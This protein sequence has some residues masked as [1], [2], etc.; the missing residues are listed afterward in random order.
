MK[1]WLPVSADYKE[2]NVAA[3]EKEP[4]SMLSLYRRLLAL[5]QSNPALAVGSYQAV[6]TGAADVFAFER[7]YAGQRLLV[8]L[9]FSGEERRIQM[10]GNGTAKVLL[11]TSLD[12]EGIVDLGDWVLP[13]NTGI[14]LEE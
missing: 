8:A 11:S 3:E 9:N 4:G 2:R 7:E 10:V 14:V 1:P 6:E 12:R 5:R 13:G